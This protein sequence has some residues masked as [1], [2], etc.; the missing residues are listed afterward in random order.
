MCGSYPYYSSSTGLSSK[1]LSSATHWE[2]HSI[3][4]QLHN[5]GRGSY[6]SPHT[7]LNHTGCS[8]DTY[9]ATCPRNT[10]I[11]ASTFV[12]ERNRASS[13]ARANLFSSG[14]GGLHRRFCRCFDSGLSVL[15]GVKNKIMSNQYVTSLCRSWSCLWLLA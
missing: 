3:G 12:V 6:Q 5:I 14:L 1:R 15:E 2:Y 7:I 13:A 9:C 4:D 10:T 8:L 11:P